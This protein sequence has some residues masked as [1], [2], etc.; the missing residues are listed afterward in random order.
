MVETE[1][2]KTRIMG[3]Y[4]GVDMAPIP[5]EE[6]GAGGDTSVEPV[7]DTDSFP[8]F[9][10]MPDGA[11]RIRI[12]D[13]AF[14][15]P[16]TLYTVPVNKELYLI[17]ISMSGRNLSGSLGYGYWVLKD[18]GD[19]VKYAF[20]HLYL[21]ANGYWTTQ[22]NF[23]PAMVLDAGDYISAEPTIQDL[24]FFTSIYGYLMNV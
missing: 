5:V 4:P 11:T 23:F 20:A 22:S 6:Q 19:S 12:F 10:R 24:K 2:D 13:A 21:A 17:T 18:S 7:S 8:V 1:N 3:I 9:G 14:H 15:V 16:T